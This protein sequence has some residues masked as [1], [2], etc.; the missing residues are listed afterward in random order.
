MPMSSRWQVAMTVRWI[1]AT[2]M[3][4][5]WRRAVVTSPTATSPMGTSLTVMGPMRPLDT[6]ATGTS[7]TDMGTMEHMI[8]AILTVIDRCESQRV[9][10]SLSLGRCSKAFEAPRLLK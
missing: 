5:A 10:L 9:F 8:M 3:L 2:I 6:R 7:R 4:R 1:M